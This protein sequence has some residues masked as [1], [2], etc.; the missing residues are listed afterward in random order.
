MLVGLSGP[1]YCLAPGD[2]YDFDAKEAQSLI[3]AEYAVPV[4]EQKIERAVKAP[5]VE[6]RK[7]K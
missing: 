5:A 7:G 6:K 2:E 3:A 1:T 4:A